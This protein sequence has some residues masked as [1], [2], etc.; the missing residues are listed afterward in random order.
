MKKVNPRML[1]RANM[2]ASITQGLYNGIGSPSTQR[3]RN[4]F[5]MHALVEAALPTLPD[6]YKPLTVT[7]KYKVNGKTFTRKITAPASQLLPAAEWQKQGKT[8]QDIIGDLE[9]EGFRAPEMGVRGA[10]FKLSRLGLIENVSTNPFEGRR[11]RPRALYFKP[12]S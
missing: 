2:W 8:V 9:A 3:V 4:P 12:V 1:R 11:G 5:P 7:A 6:P 10:L